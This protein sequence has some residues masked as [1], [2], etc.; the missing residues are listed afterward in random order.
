M[1]TR[2]TRSTRRWTRSFAA[3]VAM[4]ATALGGAVAAVSSDAVAYLALALMSLVTL[5][6]LWRFASSS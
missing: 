4:G 5:A 2:S 6:G 3:S 1:P